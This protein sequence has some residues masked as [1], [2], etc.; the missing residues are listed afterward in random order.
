[1]VCM[2]RVFDKS[3]ILIGCTA[4]LFFVP[5]ST[6]FV[7]AFLTAIVVAFLS[8]INAVPTVLFRSCIGLYLIVALFIPEFVLFIP[9]VSYDYLRKESWFL[10]LVWL[11]PLFVGL[12]F[13]ESWEIFF[14]GGMGAIMVFLALR[15]LNI[16]RELSSS[17]TLRD[18]LRE[19]S[20]SLE[21]KNRD[22]RDRQDMEVHVATLNERGRIAREIHDN[23]GHLLTRSVLQV[24][25]F[26]VIHADDE[27]IRKEFEE[28]G[29]TLH[30]AL[31]TVRASVHNLHDDAFDL[32]TQL[33]AMIAN[34]KELTIH[35]EYLAQSIPAPIGYCFIALTREAT[36]NTLKHS[37]ADTM[38][39]C[40]LEQP[41]FYRL[42]LSDNG[43]PNK[44]EVDAS[45]PLDYR[46]APIHELNPLKTGIGLRTMEERV[47]N[48]NGFF[49]LDSTDG[50]H[51]IASIPKQE[52]GG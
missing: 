36:S 48:L 35:L 5:F 19:E 40:A 43:K 11:V 22:L 3:I 15:T 10:R 25:A 4:S 32:E 1:M 24:E 38:H 20:L 8:E 12:R 49:R 45:N 33:K 39:I 16:E 29:D 42:T 50:F 14:L 41:G 34:C 21:Q 23:V 6:F 52:I 44:Q 17:L 31:S 27:T 47:R 13:F 37:T 46:M 7:V 9:L 26:Q 28:V 18:G 2:D 30:E 51:I